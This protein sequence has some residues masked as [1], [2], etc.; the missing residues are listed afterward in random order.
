MKRILQIKGEK[1]TNKYK[2]LK[3]YLEMVI[4]GNREWEKCVRNL[5]MVRRMVIVIG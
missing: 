3:F 4:G 1:G 5:S 2:Y